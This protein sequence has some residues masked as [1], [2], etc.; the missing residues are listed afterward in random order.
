[1][2]LCFNVSDVSC[3]F[4]STRWPGRVVSW[5]WAFRKVVSAVNKLAW[6]VPSKWRT[7]SLLTFFFFSFCLQ[8]PSRALAI[9]LAGAW[10]WCTAQCRA[11]RCP[12]PPCGA[13]TLQGT[14][15]LVVSAGCTGEHA[16]TRNYMK[17]SFTK[18]L[19]TKKFYL[20]IHRLNSP[21]LEIK[22]IE[23]KNGAI[24]LLKILTIKSLLLIKRVDKINSY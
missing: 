15:S 18:T 22:I 4:S 11:V 9:E 7:I 13:A 24:S 12:V 1:M 10:Q 14:H 20:Q 2:D 17:S 16:K 21:N 6:G 3:L 8:R 19:G 5:Q 23:P